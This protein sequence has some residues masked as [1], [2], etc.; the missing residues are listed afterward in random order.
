[1]LDVM[2]PGKINSF[3]NQESL[4]IFFYA[5]LSV[6]THC[7]SRTAFG[8]FQCM[9]GGL[10]VI[11]GLD[12]PLASDSTGSAIFVHTAAFPAEQQVAQ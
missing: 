11:L 5:L 1:M 6:K 7:I 10:K 12:D 4:Q 9:R 2:G 3:N 8:H